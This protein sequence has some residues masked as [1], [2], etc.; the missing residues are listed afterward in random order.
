[1]AGSRSNVDFLFNSQSINEIK[2][3]QHKLQLDIK[4]KTDDL[5]QLIM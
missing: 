5:Q 3:V 4:K 2:Q 1:M